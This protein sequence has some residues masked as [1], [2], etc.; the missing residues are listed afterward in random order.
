MSVKL[1]FLLILAGFAGLLAFATIYKYFEVRIASR[2]PSTPG[3]VVS[4]RVVQRRVGG[5]GGDEKDVELRNFAEVTYEYAVQGKKQRASRVSIGEDLGNFQ[6]EE[7]LAKYPQGA[8]V[9]VY[10]N[11]TKPGEAVL[12]RDVPEGIFK[13]MLWLILGLIA[14]GLAL[15]FGVEQLTEYLKMVLPAGR[16]VSLAVMLSGMGVFALLISLASSREA[17]RTKDWKST[18]GRIETSAVEK[19][20]TLSDSGGRQRWQTMQRAQIV[21]S[22][23]VNGREYRGDKVAEGWK[24]SATFGLLA[25]RAAAKFAQGQPVEV[26]YDPANPSRALLDRRVKGGGFTYVIAFALLAAAA[27]VAGLF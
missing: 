14:V 15:I 13:F 1:F 8:S 19:F 2:W 23:N 17:A 11:P 25:R 16:N 22:Y 26:F 20:Q 9:I 3:R 12:E 6:I 27:K 18:W 24:A 5:I 4:S 7:T 10:Y 21:Y